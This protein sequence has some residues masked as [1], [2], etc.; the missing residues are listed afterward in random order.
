[1]PPHF[2]MSTTQHETLSI[3]GMHCEHCVE[4]V[5]EALESVRGVSVESVDIGTAKV[6]YDADLV[7]RDQLAT[8][9]DDAGYDLVVA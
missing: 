3:E 2:D 7:S 5:R 9:I 1:M 8:V 4:I 6:T